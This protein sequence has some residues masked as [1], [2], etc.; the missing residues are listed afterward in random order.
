MAMKKIYLAGPDVFLPDPHAAGAAKKHLCQQY[1][2]D[3]LFPIDSEISVADDESLAFAISRENEALIHQADIIIANLT[4]FRGPS[5]DAGTVYELGL[6]RGLGKVLAGYSNVSTPFTERSWQHS[7]HGA[8]PED[9]EAPL[10]DRDGLTIENFGLHDNLML[11]GGIYLANGI[12]ITCD[13][14]PE[15]R[16]T[17]LSAFEQ[18]LKQL[19]ERI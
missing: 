14:P 1:G 11:E 19:A 4:P 18:I 2:F 7:G 3:G 17:D 9:S 10:A 8:M 12:F 13:A 5:A 15:Q 6:A 16:Y